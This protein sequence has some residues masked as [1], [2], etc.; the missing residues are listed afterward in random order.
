MSDALLRGAQNEDA[1]PTDIGERVMS[2][3]SD[4]SANG[5]RQPTIFEKAYVAAGTYETPRRFL[6]AVRSI[7]TCYA[8]G[9]TLFA[10]GIAIQ[11]WRAA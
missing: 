7:V 3:S 5:H 8:V 1:D 2:G 6:P 4:S 10:L 11:G 9:V